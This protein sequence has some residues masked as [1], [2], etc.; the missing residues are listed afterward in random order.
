[1]EFFTKPEHEQV[2]TNYNSF[3]DA[4]LLT[5]FSSIYLHT[6]TV[7]I[8]YKVGSILFEQPSVFFSFPCI[9]SRLEVVLTY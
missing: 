3:D 9:S 1:M 5:K 8:S 7:K 2:C 4:L 6:D